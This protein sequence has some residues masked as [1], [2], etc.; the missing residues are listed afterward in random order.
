MRIWI[1]RATYALGVQILIFTSTSVYNLHLLHYQ[2]VSIFLNFTTLSALFLNLFMQ[3]CDEFYYTISCFPRRQY[4]SSKDVLKGLQTENYK[5]MHH[6][7][8]CSNEQC[9]M[10]A[11][12]YKYDST[13][14]A[15]STPLTLTQASIYQCPLDVLL[16]PA[17]RLLD[18]ALFTPLLVRG[19]FPVVFDAKV[20]KAIL[21]GEEMK[22]PARCNFVPL[23]LDSTT[24]E[25]I[26]HSLF[27]ESIRPALQEKG[28]PCRRK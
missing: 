18:E 25:V 21:S 2:L 17:P 22:L 3:S 20:G 28:L 1:P 26:R 12:L 15:S 24:R 6:H 7:S 27:Y 16:A 9:L 19:E 5:L 4:V 8:N 10:N 14:G 23:I 13:I 11:Y